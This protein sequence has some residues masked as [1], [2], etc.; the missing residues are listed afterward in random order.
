[1]CVCADSGSVLASG[2]PDLLFVFAPFLLSGAW[3]ATPKITTAGSAVQTRLRGRMGEGE[4][5]SERESGFEENGR[6]RTIGA[7]SSS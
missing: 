2:G 6:V 1:V 3:M 4:T 5:E 7:M